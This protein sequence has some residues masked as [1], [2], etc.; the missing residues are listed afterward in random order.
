MICSRCIRA[1]SHNARSQFQVTRKR[2]LATSSSLSAQSI[3]AATATQAVPNRSPPAATSTSAAQPFSTPLT[4]APDESPRTGKAKGAGDRA[5]VSISSVP[6][7]TPLKGLNFLKNG[8]DPVAKEDSEYP[9]WLW[10]VLKPK[11]AS[12]DVGVAESDLFCEF[13]LNSRPPL[14]G[15]QETIHG[16]LEF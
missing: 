4:P 14:A 9:S 7:G 8:T 12:S 1:A 10:D 15:D 2:T 16:I 5:A 13:P 11:E 3:S 6:A